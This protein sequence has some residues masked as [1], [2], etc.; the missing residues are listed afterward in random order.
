MVIRNRFQTTQ[1]DSAEL[2]FDI[3][4]LWAC[5]FVNVKI[6]W[7]KNENFYL[8]AYIMYNMIMHHAKFVIN[9]MYNTFLWSGS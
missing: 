1:D 6:N 4:K 8:I 7:D 2:S 5:N 9:Y 3:W